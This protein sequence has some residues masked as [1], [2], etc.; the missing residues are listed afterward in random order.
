MQSNNERSNVRIIGCGHC[1]NIGESE[2]KDHNVSRCPILEKI[3]CFSCKNYGH[4]RSYCPEKKKAKEEQSTPIQVVAPAVNCWANIL[5]KALTEE[6]KAAVEAEDKKVKDAYQK[7]LEKKKKEKHDAWLQKKAKQEEY[8]K[9]KQQQYALEQEQ[10]EKNFVLFKTHMQFEHGYNWI[11][12]FEEPHE[13]PI[14][15]SFH[16]RI[17]KMIQEDRKEEWEMEQAENKRWEAEKAEKAALKEKMKSELSPELYKRWKKDFE[18]DEI[19][20]WC[21]NGSE[22]YS[23]DQRM[24]YRRL[25]EGKIWLKEQMRI[26][27]I[28][29]DKEGNYQYYSF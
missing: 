17:E 22:Q 5:K 25:E 26:G 4:T 16:E 13:K 1:R 2:W 19:D 10:E 14:P 8:L 21:Q 18:Y 29:K 23:M 9:L 3:Q 28:S 6:D 27:T 24:I 20:T 15:R 12:L 7:I 11:Y